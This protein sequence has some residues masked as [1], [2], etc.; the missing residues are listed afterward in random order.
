MEHEMTYRVQYYETDTMGIVHHSNY[1]RYFET[2]RT[3]FVRAA[4]LPYDKIEEMG[5]YIPV[6]SVKAEYKVPAVYDE[7]IS[8]TCRMTKLSH[9]SFE[10]EYEVKNAETGQLHA[11][12]WSRHGF[13]DKSFKPI[14]IKK[15]A[16][17]VYEVFSKTYEDGRKEDGQKK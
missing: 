4:G 10:L 1:I 15:A 6:L 7:V 3:E 14:V 11:K 13:T 2:V 17:E 12:G 16:P 8:L 5:V 9:A